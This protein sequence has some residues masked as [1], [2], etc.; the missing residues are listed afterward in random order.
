MEGMVQSVLDY[1]VAHALGIGALIVC[2][3]SFLEYVFPPFPGDA[4]T[5]LGAWLVVKG[6]WSFPFALAVVT[7]GSLLGAAAD[8][9]IGRWLAG[10]LERPKSEKSRFLGLPLPRPEQLAAFQKKFQRWGGW[11]IVVNRFMPGIRA[12]FFVAAGASRI[13]LGL[14][15]LL[16][17]L[18][19]VAWNS[20]LLWVGYS[21]GQNWQQLRDW[22][23][24]YTGVVWIVLGAVALLFVVYYI[25][26]RRKSRN[27]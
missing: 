6:A 22:L 5:L 23:S 27:V 19:A 20:M 13:S 8:W 12:F 24:S 16:A 7:T 9:G 14:V 11:L 15:L 10:K 26:K 17:G 21:V 1:V 3:S 2:A 25:L 18:S 4:V